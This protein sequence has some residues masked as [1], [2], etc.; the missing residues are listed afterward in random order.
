MTTAP[1]LIPVED[2][3]GLPERSRALLS[4]DG[5]TV[6]YLAPW[7]GRLNVFL[8]DVDSDWTADDTSDRAARRITSDSRRTIDT[9]FWSP[10]GRYLLYYQDTDGDEN[11][12]LHRVDVARPDEPAADLT[13]FPGVRLLDTRF[14]VDRP[15]IAY[16]Q[17][18]R[19]RPDLGDLYELDL[20]TGVLTVVAEN[21]GDIVS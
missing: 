12:H 1:R 6:A 16:V 21:P 11:W 9:F 15:D 3:Y 10:D 8:R 18:N 14:P 20:N 4:P 7:R 17:L 19:R 13:P 5:H 2:F